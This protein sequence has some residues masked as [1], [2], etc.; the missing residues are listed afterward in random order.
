MF[1][2][3]KMLHGWETSDIHEVHCKEDPIDV[4]PEMKLRGLV[5]NSYIHVPV[6]DL[7]IPMIEFSA[8]FLCRFW[9]KRCLKLRIPIVRLTLFCAGV[10]WTGHEYPVPPP[11]LQIP[12]FLHVKH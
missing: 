6:S 3:M 8:Q 11:L 12:R 7:Y 10:P 9:V 5:L 4:F 1:K 2:T